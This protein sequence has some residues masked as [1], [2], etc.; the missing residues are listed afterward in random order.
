MSVQTRADKRR[1]ARNN[2]KSAGWMVF[3]S[4]MVLAYMGSTTIYAGLHGDVIFGVVIGGF[5]WI[6]FGLMA[7]MAAKTGYDEWRTYQDLKPE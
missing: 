7:V 1:R 6:V 3:G 5:V 4:L 2:A